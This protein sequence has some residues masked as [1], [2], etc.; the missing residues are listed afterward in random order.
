MISEHA[1]FSSSLDP[2]ALFDTLQEAQ[3]HERKVIARKFIQKEIDNEFDNEFTHHISDKF[4]N[5]FVDGLIQGLCELMEW[6]L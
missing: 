5:A 4:T 2:A 3:H 6:E 1:K